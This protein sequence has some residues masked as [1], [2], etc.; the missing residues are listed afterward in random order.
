MEERTLGRTDLV[1]PVIGLGTALRSTFQVPEGEEDR[2]QEVV[3]AALEA[4]VRLFDTSPMYGRSEEILAQALGSRR[5][6]SVIATK[7]W[8]DTLVEVRSQVARQLDLFAG[9]VEILQIHNLRGW[10]THLPYL[11]ELHARSAIRA[12]G[13]THHEAEALPELVRVMEERVLHSIQIPYNPIEREVERHVLPLAREL[14]IGVIALRPL[15]K[16]KLRPPASSE[17]GRL[18]VRTWGQALL[19]WALSDRRVTAVIPAT[20]S[21][22]R[23]FEN[24]E[25]GDPPWFTDE[26]RERVSWL[27]RASFAN[28]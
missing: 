1:L 10:Q 8:A 26:E 7:V 28:T 20:G 19:K 27:A 21:S 3:D 4:G 25:A 6:V 24:A 12:V 15:A 11:V 2:A 18:N 9:R 17:L 23:P 14:G 16:G 5:A 22:I 13:A